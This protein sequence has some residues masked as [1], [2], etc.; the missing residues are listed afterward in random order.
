MKKIISL[1][2]L[3]L[4]LVLALSLT[5]SVPAAEGAPIYENENDFST[6]SSL[7]ILTDST[8]AGGVKTLEDGSK[9]FYYSFLG[10]TMTSHGNNFADV[11]IG[12]A[13]ADFSFAVIDMD[14]A[15]EGEFPSRMTAYPVFRDTAG[16]PHYNFDNSTSFGATEAGGVVYY[17]EEQIALGA[18]NSWHHYTWIVGND[19]ENIIQLCFVDGEMLYSDTVA[20]DNEASLGSFRLDVASAYAV[21]GEGFRADNVCVRVYG[22]D[23][24]GG[25]SSVVSGGDITS[26][27]GNLYTAEYQLPSLGCEA[28]V[29]DIFFTTV[30]DAVATLEDGDTLK[31]FTEDY[32]TLNIENALTVVTASPLKYY[33]KAYTASYTESEGVYTYVFTVA[34]ESDLAYVDWYVDLDDETAE[35]LAYTAG[36]IPVYYGESR[37]DTYIVGNE[38]YFAN[39]LLDAEGVAVA[40]LLPLVAGE[41]LTL[42]V[43]RSVSTESFAVIDELGNVTKYYDPTELTNAFK[44]M[45]PGSTMQLLDDIVGRTF[46][47]YF[48]TT[49]PGEYGFDFNG[50]DLICEKK[51]NIF[52]VGSANTVLNVYSSRPGG[53]IFGKSNQTDLSVGE[54]S[55]VVKLSG[56]N[57]VVNLGAY[58]NYPGSNLSSYTAALV[59][60]TCNDGTCTVNINGGNY[61]RSLTDWSGYIIA[62]KSSGIC[63]FN[64]DGARLIGTL[65]VPN[66]NIVAE[67]ATVNVKNSLVMCID[68]NSGNLCSNLGLGS[69]VTLDNCIINNMVFQ[70]S[71]HAKASAGSETPEGVIVVKNTCS[72]V[73]DTR[74]AKV[75]YATLPS[76]SAVRVNRMI[77]GVIEYNVFGTDLSN[78]S[79]DMITYEGSTRGTYIYV[80][81]NETETADVEWEY[82]G[83]YYSETWLVGE[84]PFPPFK[85]PED[86]ATTRYILD[87]IEPV[88]DYAIYSL[89][90]HLNFTPLYNFTLNATSFNINVYVPTAATGLISVNVGG[91]PI[92]LDGD[93]TALPTVEIDGVQY[94]KLTKKDVSYTFTGN[95]YKATIYAYS[96][97]D[98]R[99][100]YAE[101]LTLSVAS[102][103]SAILEGDF[104]EQDKQNVKDFVLVASRAYASVGAAFPESLK[105]YLED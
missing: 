102:Y 11:E 29:N 85:I 69:S 89:T 100:E 8:G 95:E 39:G 47:I 40:E 45:V 74:F 86:N 97:E 16:V 76:G 73:K 30:E 32:G 38:C 62:R 93:L 67:R 94:Y 99:M 79:Y 46:S 21:M 15:A 48:S 72:F 31:L 20:I 36:S 83:D 3:L 66:F 88:T 6:D 104:A 70:A 92:S 98:S 57:S 56:K 19:G 90:P 84:M 22:N 26:W 51:N 10:Q 41:S 37:A 75:D 28:S 24:E 60:V 80:N 54:G 64:I 27:A 25:L 49:F 4:A 2:S 43:D 78:L 42:R 18:E 53:R 12:Y 105:K 59:D 7:G 87:T 52:Q 14:F 44:R 68:G 34:T 77:E 82:F 91:A 33:S 58:G 81:L 50:Y 96:K 17:G 55:N 65:G 71:T 1:F 5:L 103:V 63:N 61:Y 35:R 13:L 23:Y 101:S 9:Y